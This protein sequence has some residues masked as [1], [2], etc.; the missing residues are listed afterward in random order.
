M[1]VLSLSSLASRVDDPTLRDRIGGKALSTVLLRRAGVP[2]LDSVVVSGPAIAEHL[3]RIAGD[4]DDARAS[5]A[6]GLLRGE[7]A[8]RA[9]I[10]EE[11]IAPSLVEA[12]LQQLRDAPLLIVRSSG[13]HEDSAA[14]SSVASSSLAG[15]YESIV[16]LP[17]VEAV[18]HAMRACLTRGLHVFVD[19]VLDEQAR[20][21]GLLGTD[22]AVRALLERA[23]GALAL[24]V[25]PVVDAARSGVCFTRSPLHPRA[26]LVVAIPGTCHPVVDGTLAVDTFVVGDDGQIDRLVRHTFEATV[27]RGDVDDLLP[28]QPIDT[29][30][31][32]TVFHA[33][34]G[35]GLA[36]VRCPEPSASAAALNDDELAEVIDVA[37]RCRDAIGYEADVEFSFGAHGLI[38]L[39]ARPIT[40]ALPDELSSDVIEDD[41]ADNRVLGEGLVAAR[42]I[43]HGPLRRVL[44]VDDLHRVEV[45]D[46]LCVTATDPDFMEALYKAAAI[47]SEDGSPLSHTAIVARE[48]QKPCIVG[49]RGA[50]R[51]PEDLDVVV[52]AVRGRVLR[53]S[54]ADACEA[55]VVE[56][57]DHVLDRLHRPWPA[58]PVHVAAS[59]VLDGWLRAHPG[60]GLDLA[61]GGPSDICAWLTTQLRTAGCPLAGVVWDLVDDQLSPLDR[62]PVFAQLRAALCLGW[63]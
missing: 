26:A 16:C 60:K 20:Q 39:Q 30:L 37:R 63:S 34:Y 50:T 22:I 61:I 8:A 3:W 46:V 29:P 43:A 4:D 48:L 51:W 27:V 54:E 7:P 49:V 53:A 17:T 57:D 28:G 45:G 35:P 42:G 55:E 33:R 59:A 18:D 15:H 10:A 47:V 62:D 19:L 31:G 44:S 36:Q 11:P 13:I 24:L 32:P 40:T 6:R 14:G 56:P 25:Q 38:V 2:V 12:V 1:T 9:Q 58:G 23:V 41:S 5:F 21:V 52:D